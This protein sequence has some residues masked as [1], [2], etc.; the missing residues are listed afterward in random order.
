MG[1]IVSTPS[2]RLEGTQRSGHQVFC[3]IPYARPP[4]NG[5]RFRAPVRPEPWRD[6]RPARR[7]GRAAP[8]VGRANRLVR[9]FIGV[10]DVAQSQDCLYLNVWTPASDG[11]RRPVMVWFHGGAFILG[12]GSTVLYDGAQLVHEGDVVVVT[13]NYR[14]GALGYLD[15]RSLAPGGGDLPEANLG[16]RDQIAVLE[17]VRDHIECFGGDPEKITIFGESAGGMSVGTLLGTPRARGLFHAAI[18]Q[19]GAA[20][21][22]ATRE[23]AAVAARHFFDSLGIRQP[24]YEVLERLTVAE[25]M[26]AQLQ[27][28]TELGFLEGILPFQPSLDDDLIPAPPLRS[29]GNG[30]ARGVPVMVGTNRDEWKLFMV[31]DPRAFNFREEQLKRRFERVLSRLGDRG[32]DLTRRAFETYYRVWGPRGG[33]VADRWAAFQSDRI[34]HYP[35]SRLAD[36]QCPYS[37]QTWAYLF[38]WSPPLIGSRLG[39]CHGLELPFVFGTLRHPLLRPFGVV[40]RGAYRLARHMQRAWVHFARTGCPAHD[41]LPE[42]PAYTLERRSTLAFGSEYTL[43]DDPHERA[44]GFWGDIIPN[45]KLPWAPAELAEGEAA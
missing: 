17:W 2:G 45:A 40:S 14:L 42:W 22:V 25:I 32:P 1:V 38:E 36:L 24:S 12:S 39:A 35:A 27:T 29:I 43:R 18:L 13:C 33:E 10:A 3:G 41:E 8:Q 6:V 4:L 26:R 37:E 16:V 44:R 34:F 11:A 7:F 28:I 19:S 21:N 31:S 9:A 20:H 30:S 15:W 5:L 23:Q